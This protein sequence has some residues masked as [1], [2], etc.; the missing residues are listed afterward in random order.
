MHLGALDRC[1]W[2]ST[3]LVVHLGQKYSAFRVLIFAVALQ[4]HSDFCCIFID[5]G[6]KSHEL[7]LISFFSIK[8]CV[9]IIIV[10]AFTTFYLTLTH[11]KEIENI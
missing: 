5:Q 9:R 6:K 3:T 8:N 2:R 10:T 7:I 4:N 11:H 1:E